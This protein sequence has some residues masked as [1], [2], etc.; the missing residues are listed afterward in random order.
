MKEMGDI[1]TRR[2]LEMFDQNFGDQPI[3]TPRFVPRSV[4]LSAPPENVVVESAKPFVSP[5]EAKLDNF[6]PLQVDN[7]DTT[8]TIS[9]ASETA[10]TPRE[11]QSNG[12]SSSHG[13][14]PRKSSLLSKI[15]I[16]KLNLPSLKSGSKSTSPHRV[17][18][19]ANNDQNSKIKL[20][21]PPKINKPT[22]QKTIT[23]KPENSADSD[24]DVSFP[25]VEQE[26]NQQSQKRDSFHATFPPVEEEH[27]P[28]TKLPPPPF[29]GTTVPKK[30]GTDHK[31][32]FGDDDFNPSFPPVEQ[33]HNHTLKREAQKQQINAQ[34][35]ADNDLL[36]F[37]IPNVNHAQ[38]PLQK[39]PQSSQ[40]V[41]NEKWD[42]FGEDKFEPVPTSQQTTQKSFTD[43]ILDSI[44]NKPIEPKK[45]E[46]PKGTT[47]PILTPP[48]ITTK[49]GSRK[50]IVRR[51]QA[52]EEKPTQ[53]AEKAIPQALNPPRIT[54]DPNE[55][56]QRKEVRLLP[57]TVVVTELINAIYKNNKLEA[58][59][60]VGQIA[61]RKFQ[62]GSEVHHYDQYSF[63]LH[64]KNTERI[65]QFA[66]NPKFCQQIG[67]FLL[68][69]LTHFIAQNRWRCSIP[70]SSFEDSKS[71]S[72]VTLLRYTLRP[73]F[74]PVPLQAL[75]RIQL[76]DRSINFMLQYKINPDTPL[77]NLSFLV[78]PIDKN[79]CTGLSVVNFQSKPEGK[80][81]T[82]QEK[83]LW[84]IQNAVYD[85]APKKLLAMFIT[86]TSPKTIPHKPGPVLVKFF[87]TGS[88]FA[89]VVIDGCDQ[90]KSIDNEC[91]VG[92]VEYQ[93]QAG[94]YEYYL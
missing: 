7:T 93:M 87:N 80:W 3:V 15:P 50:V 18:Q 71:G 35:K 29:T 47:N 63:S 1:L 42:P 70:G 67:K 89:S 91:F 46:Q 8:S 57:L 17:H 83:L 5:R 11:Q 54:F 61:V 24:F 22:N 20:P 49:P 38:K 12:T 52:K 59:Q 79:S 92:G 53:Q 26:D 27:K 34:Q 32:L 40:P 64:V 88:S 45:S 84:R 75:P 30:P 2:S 85:K 23:K 69:L 6:T 14:K 55:V 73:E 48:T 90:K 58:Y 94:K 72:Q 21:P 62:Y 65:Q 43:N 74:K 19:E 82:Q 28:N 25:P 77:K 31:N 51:P 78:C 76:T 4:H 41:S 39:P 36:N 44:L 56:L 60:L 13:S 68:I 16:P 66:A 37:I 10:K 86:N 81:S 9:D 33:D